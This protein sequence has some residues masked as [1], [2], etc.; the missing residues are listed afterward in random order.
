MA[1]PLVRHGASKQ[2]AASRALGSVPCEWRGR[3][4]TVSSLQSC[5]WE[6]TPACGL[7]IPL[8]C[9]HTAWLAVCP[10]ENDCWKYFYLYENSQ[11]VCPFLEELGILNKNTSSTTLHTQIFQDPCSIASVYHHMFFC[12]TMA[13]AY[14]LNRVE[15]YILLV[16]C[17]TTGWWCNL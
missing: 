16:L 17:N 9:T 5:K 10:A 8:E 3:D 1:L 6:M 12:T 7:G 2:P 11:P 4:S 14:I 15:D 13:R